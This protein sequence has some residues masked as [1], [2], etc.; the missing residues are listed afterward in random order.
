L[1]HFFQLFSVRRR[2]DIFFRFRLLAAAFFYAFIYSAPAFAAD[3]YLPIQPRDFAAFAFAAAA[4]LMPPMQL[5]RFADFRDADDFFA[6]LRQRSH[7]AADMITRPIRTAELLR[8]ADVFPNAGFH[9]F[10]FISPPP[11][12]RTIRFRRHFSIRCR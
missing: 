8:F 11:S 7:G 2:A 1:L 3:R 12:P 5:R 4:V 6:V 10:Y 9:D